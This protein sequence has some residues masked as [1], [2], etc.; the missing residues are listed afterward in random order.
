MRETHLRNGAASF[1]VDAWT[2]WA[3]ADLDASRAAISDG[4]A[5]AREWCHVEKG[6]ISRANVKILTN[7]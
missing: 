2:E 4:R 1:E 7:V 5:R 6:K 3:G